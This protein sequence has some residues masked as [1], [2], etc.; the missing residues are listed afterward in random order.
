MSE[1][2]RK[3]L[4]AAGLDAD[5]IEIVA[6][7]VEIPGAIPAE[8]REKARKRW[9]FAADEIVLEC[10]AALTEEKG[11]ALLIEAFA[12]LRRCPGGGKCRLLLAGDGRLRPQLEQRAREAGVESRGC[13]RGLCSRRR[14]GLRG[15][16]SFCLSVAPGRSGKLSAASDGFWFAGGGAGARRRGRDH[17]RRKKWSAGAGSDAGSAGAGSRADA[18]RP[19]IDGT[20]IAGR[21]GDGGGTLFGGSHDRRHGAYFRG[22]D[23]GKSREA[24]KTVRVRKRESAGY[25]L[26]GR[27]ALISRNFAPVSSPS[28]SYP[29]RLFPE[30]RSGPRTQWPTGSRNSTPTA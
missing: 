7:G 15:G 14:S 20:A 26:P 29:C 8:T 24:D 21:A 22:V 19:S 9:G 11:H 25:P 6:D 12:K 2:V 10:V 3:Q 4:L 23:F 13:I 16:R 18:R 17:R 5:R 28:S 27:P 1:A 30:E